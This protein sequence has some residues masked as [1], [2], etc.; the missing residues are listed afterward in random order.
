MLGKTA[1]FLSEELRNGLQMISSL[2]TITF[3]AS[4]FYIE[5]VLHFSKSSVC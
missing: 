5:T 4:E 3:T 2:A 1:G